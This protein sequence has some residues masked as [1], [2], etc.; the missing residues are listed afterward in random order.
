MR[1]PASPSRAGTRVSAHS[2]ATATAIAAARPSLPMKA[3][4]EAYRP[5]TAMITV[6]AAIRTDRPLV[7][8][9]GRPLGRVDALHDVLPVPGG[10]EQRV[11]DADA[12]AHHHGERGRDAGERERRGGHA[13]HPEG[14]GRPDHG[15]EDGQPRRQHAAEAEQQDDDRHD[16]ADQLRPAVL[17]LRPG[18]LAER[19]AVADGDPGRAGRGTA[20]PPG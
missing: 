8:T 13:E 12:E 9:V 1:R 11:V 4:P 18:G 20:G 17:G 2:A 15:G 14:G 10:Q 3:M 7:P 16:D 19:A 6:T 5:S